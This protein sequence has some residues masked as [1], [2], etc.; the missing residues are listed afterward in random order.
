V[1]LQWYVVAAYLAG[2]V[3][4]Y[5]WRGHPRPPTWLLFVPGW[6]L[7][8]P[9]FVIAE[10]GPVLVLPLALAGLIVFTMVLRRRSLAAATLTVGALALF[11]LTP[12][13]ETIRTFTLD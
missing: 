11:M 1:V 8:V 12:L 2:A 13:G 6:L 4:P 3:L 7:G 9:G 5:L 10:F